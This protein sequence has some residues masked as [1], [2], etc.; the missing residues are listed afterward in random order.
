MT[1]VSSCPQCG[2]PVTI[3]DGIA[4]EKA[5]RCPLCGEQFPLSRALD[6]L[7]P[8]LIP[9]DE[10]STSPEPT[11]PETGEKKAAGAAPL[12]D[13][14]QTPVDADALAQMGT[15]QPRTPTAD[16]EDISQQVPLQHHSKQH[17]R[18]QKSVLREMIGAVLGGFLGLAVG[19]YLLNWIGGPRFDF[20]KIY[21]PG[22]PHASQHWPTPLEENNGDT[23]DADGPRAPAASPNTTFALPVIEQNSPEKDQAPE[24]DQDRP[25][26]PEEP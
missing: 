13:T 4:R 18:K 16:A 20:L 2:R 17:R 12:I 24:K 26:I 23:P 10:P 14:G 21:L 19:Y 5:V 8:A 11:L 6:D 15:D 25:T 22:V 7:P 1:L 9:V 3:P